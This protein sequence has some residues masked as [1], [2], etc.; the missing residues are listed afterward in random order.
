M[1]RE[2]WERLPWRFGWKHE[3]WDG[4]ARLTPH[5]HHVHV[6][7]PIEAR[8]KRLPAVAS[9]GLSVR[10]VGPADAPGL[11]P[12]FIEAFEDGV[13]FCDWPA[14]RIQEHA[15]R[16]VADY[17]AGRRGVPLLAAS[18]LAVEG[19][20][21]VGAALLTRRRDGGPTLDLLMVSPA[22]RRRGIARALV[23]AAVEELRGQSATGVLRS[24]YCVANRESA[25]WHRAFGFEEEPDL[26]LAR[27]RQAFYRHEVSRHG[28]DEAPA[29]L[30]SSYEHWS[31][32][33][34][35]LE[36]IA[37]RQGFEAVTPSLSYGS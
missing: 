11:V 17:F 37:R 29:H 16:N 6:R 31:R 36:E 15:R 27:L 4:R 14:E 7:V 33:A 26:H 3:Y 34:E 2:E 12:A 21:V 19:G 18:R 30:R 32:R 24:A 28:T 20:R 22:L 35:E 5:Q 1:T 13:E 9:P 10:A 25:H 8:E 23:G